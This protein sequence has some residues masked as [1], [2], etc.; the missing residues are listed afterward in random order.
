MIAPTSHPPLIIPPYHLEA[1]VNYWHHTVIQQ[2]MSVVKDAFS[3]KKFAGQ[4]EG[5]VF[6]CLGPAASIDCKEIT[7]D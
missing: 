6:M 5:V 3:C 1:V 2:E 7:G 4:E